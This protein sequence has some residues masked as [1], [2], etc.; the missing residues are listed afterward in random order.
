MGINAGSTFE[1]QFGTTFGRN[2]AGNQSTQRRDAQ[3]WM[4]IG[5]QAEVPTDSGTEGETETVFVS[6]P[7]GI[8]LDTQE[9]FDL[10]KIRNAKMASLRDAQNGLLEQVMD[11][12]NALAPGEERILASD[13][14]GLCIQVRRVN[15]AAEAPAEGTNSLRKPLK[16]VA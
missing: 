2:S 3:L 14:N 4:N 5:Y 13:K 1:G 8:P 11:V 9:A 12:A 6:L 15:A 10:A 7:Y 16:L